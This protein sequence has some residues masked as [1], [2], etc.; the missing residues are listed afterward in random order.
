MGRRVPGGDRRQ[1]QA[2]GLEQGRAVALRGGRAELGEEQRQVRGQRPLEQPVTSRRA[3]VRPQHLHDGTERG[4]AP[5][6]P[7]ALEHLQAGAGQRPPGQGGLAHP[8][9]A[10]EQDQRSPTGEGVDRAHPQQRQLAL[11]ADELVIHAPN[12][13]NLGRSPGSAAIGFQ[14]AG[15]P[16]H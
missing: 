1:G 7:E 8:G 12:L 11:P 4:G 3:Q 15:R 5:M 9:L 6:D 14:G 13:L 10:G 2:D 16:L